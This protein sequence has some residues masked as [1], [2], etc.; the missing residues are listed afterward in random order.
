MVT[1]RASRPTRVQGYRKSEVQRNQGEEW[2]VDRPAKRQRSRLQEG[3]TAWRGEERDPT[4]EERGEHLNVLDVVSGQ[5]SCGES[6]RGPEQHC[7][8]LPR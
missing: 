5:Q 1:D 2:G 6:F 4:P 3:E 7:Q 8:F